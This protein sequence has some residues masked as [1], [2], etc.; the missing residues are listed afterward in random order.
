MRSLDYSGSGGGA[1]L[2]PTLTPRAVALAAGA[3]ARKFRSM[4]NELF[5]VLEGEGES[6]IGDVTHDWR[7]NDVFT[8]P[9]WSWA[10]HQAKGGVAHM[11]VISDAEIM[12]RLDLYREETG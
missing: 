5:V 7:K 4:A 2:L 9:H 11:I 3:P 6:R 10:R 1:P 12:K 8:V